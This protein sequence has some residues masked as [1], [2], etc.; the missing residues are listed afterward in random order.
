MKIAL[1][2]PCTS[3]N[4]NWTNIQES[5]FYN[6]TL[7]TFL[8]TQNPEHTYHFYIGVDNDDVLFNS[9]ATKSFLN[10]FNKIFKNVF[11]NFEVFN[12]KK[13]HLTKMWNVL[14]QNAYIDSCNYFYQCG[15]D[16]MFCTKGWVNDSIAIL[17]QHNDIGLTGPYNNNPHILTQA[18]VS[19]KH[20]EIFGYFFPENI[21]NWGCDDWYNYV[22]KPDYFFPLKNHYCSNEG[23]EPRYVIDNNHSFTSNYVENITEL[24]NR[25]QRQGINDRIKIINYINNQL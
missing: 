21:F 5:Y 20:M 15:D 18:F 23:G 11:F 19:R 1:L 16:I 3:K 4:H 9:T 8:L 14:Y 25:T 22:Y 6:M 7:K 10:N 24:R 13:G 2:I 12:I 17:E